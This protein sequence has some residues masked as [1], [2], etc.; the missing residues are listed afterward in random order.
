M[1][2]NLKRL[3][4]GWTGSIEVDPKQIWH[5]TSALN[6]GSNHIHYSNS[7]VDRLIDKAL[8]EINRDKKNQNFKKSISINC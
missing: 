2:E 5:S 3:F 7:E 8:I 1:K 6:N 4:L